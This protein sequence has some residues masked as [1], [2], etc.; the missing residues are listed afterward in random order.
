MP[1]PD[2]RR[3]LGDLALVD[4]TPQDL[5]EAAIATLADR[6]PGFEPA[7]ANTEVVLIEALAVEVA[8]LVYALNRVPSGVLE[9]FLGLLGAGRDLGAPP[10]GF[11]VMYPAEPGVEVTIPAGTRFR[12]ELGDGL[13]PVDWTLDEDTTIGEEDENAIAGMTGTTNTATA[14]GPHYLDPLIILDAVPLTSAA[15]IGAPEGGRGPET[16]DDYL[17]RASQVLGRLTETLVMPAHFEARALERTDLGVYRARA[18]NLYNA[19]TESIATGH[20]TVAVRA[21]EG[22]EVTSLGRDTLQADLAARALASLVI[23]VISATVTAVDVEAVV[24]IADG[25]D[26]TTVLAEVVAALTA[27][28]NPDTWEWG[29]TVRRNELIAVAAGV[30]GVDYVDDVLDE[31]GGSSIADITLTGAANLASAG[32]VTA[33]VPTP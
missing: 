6:L 2:L 15:V 13:E 33:V 24:V 17:E 23:H 30:E 16:G 14:N 10:V 19:D 11:L 18:L 9:A 27:Y 20:V 31:A 3:Y 12:L 22:L 29:D 32:T 26:E 7:E 1:S 8:Q 5:A 25:Y 4:L 28:L 21:A